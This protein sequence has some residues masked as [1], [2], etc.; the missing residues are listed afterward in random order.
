M[1]AEKHIYPSRV[2]VNSEIKKI[3]SETLSRQITNSVTFRSLSSGDQIN[4]TLMCPISHS[5]ILS[6]ASRNT[7]GMSTLCH[8]SMI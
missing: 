2:N 4:R 1:S 7:S 6:T 3:G 8:E 5:T